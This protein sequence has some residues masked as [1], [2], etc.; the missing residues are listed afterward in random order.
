MPRAAFLLSGGRVL[1]LPDQFLLLPGE[2][3]CGTR[4]PLTLG[5]QRRIVVSYQLDSEGAA[6]SEIIIPDEV[7]EALKKL[8][9]DGK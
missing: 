1:L 7:R 3:G 5:Q 2:S 4:L 9:K 8:V 6:M